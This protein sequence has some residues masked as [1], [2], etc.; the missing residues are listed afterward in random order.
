MSFVGFSIS[1]SQKRSWPPAEEDGHA[2]KKRIGEQSQSFHPLLI[3]IAPVLLVLLLSLSDTF[4]HPHSPCTAD[5][6]DRPSDARLVEVHSK[7]WDRRDLCQ[8]FT[9]KSRL[10]LHT[11]MHCKSVLGCYI[12]IAPPQIILLL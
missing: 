3:I 12:Q 11:M 1:A 9:T 7:I 5:D 6:A 10:L 8:N 2:A 4:K